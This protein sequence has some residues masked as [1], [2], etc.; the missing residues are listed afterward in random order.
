MSADP[1]PAPAPVVWLRHCEGLPKAGVPTGR[2]AAESI[3][4]LHDTR[5]LRGSLSK[6]MTWEAAGRR[7]SLKP[8][9]A[10]EFEAWQAEH[11]IVWR[12]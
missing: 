10:E 4:Y 5:N 1:A 3:P 7:F 12:G 8:M 11:G 6:G 9:T 2:A